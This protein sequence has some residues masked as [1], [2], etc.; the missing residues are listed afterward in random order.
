[1]YQ[2]SHDGCF[3]IASKEALVEFLKNCWMKSTFQVELLAPVRY[4]DLRSASRVAPACPLQY[5]Q[6]THRT[7]ALRLRTNSVQQR[8][9]AGR[10]VSQ[11]NSALTVALIMYSRVRLICISG[12][13]CLPSIDGQI[14]MEK[15]PGYFVDAKSPRRVRAL[16]PLMQLILVV[17]NPI[18][19]ALSDYA[20]VRN[21]Q[22]HCLWHWYLVGNWY[23]SSV[24]VHFD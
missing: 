13:G 24:A 12:G 21:D 18:T 11:W 3:V 1:M 20:Q 22:S 10:I 19:R 2:K 8:F 14:T 5:I 9:A 6:H 17:R 23:N 4:L 7:T 16:N 15:T